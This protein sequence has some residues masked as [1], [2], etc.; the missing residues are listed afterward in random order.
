MAILTDL[1]EK[2]AD[3]NK[4]LGFKVTDYA[5]DL[6]MLPS[7]MTFSADMQR[8]QTRL[9]EFAYLIYQTGRK[10]VA[11]GIEKQRAL[12]SMQ[13]SS[14][15]QLSVHATKAQYRVPIDQESDNAFNMLAHQAPTQQ[16]RTQQLPIQQLPTE[17]SVLLPPSDGPA[18]I[19]TEYS[20]LQLKEDS[21]SLALEPLC[22]AI[23]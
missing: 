22:S 15:L 16:L 20:Q 4:G 18:A 17:R 6:G 5:I 14:E 19:G 9:L 23:E 8:Q 1:N 10:P 7:I 21:V 13:P 3:I 11:F 12:E 2:I